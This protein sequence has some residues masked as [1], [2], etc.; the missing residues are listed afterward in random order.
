MSV[1]ILGN[2][3]SRLLYVD[4]IKEWEDEIWGCNFI[5]LEMGDRLA[6][7]TGH[8]EIMRRAR[9]WK[10]Y[11]NHKY[12]ITTVKEKQALPER[13]RGNSGMC[14][15]ALAVEQGY[16]DIQLCGFDLSGK[17]VW[18]P[19]LE[20]RNILSGLRVKLKHIF[21]TYPDS[22]GKINMW[23]FIDK[24]KLNDLH[25]KQHIMNTEY[26][27]LSDRYVPILDPSDI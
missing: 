20:D 9:V 26:Q 2:G 13:V 22:F 14:L 1:L 25:H 4:K 6:R 16:T 18:A 12:K 10:H 8:D 17:D 5:Y 19:G 11:H 23:G 15:V 27:W 7:I 3:I 21:K 24:D